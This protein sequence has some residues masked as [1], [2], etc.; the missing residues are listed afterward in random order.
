[1]LDTGYL[2]LVEAERR[3]RFS[4]DIL[5]FARS[6]IQ[7]H[8]DFGELSRVVSSL[9]GRSSEKAQTGINHPGSCNIANGIH[10]NG[11]SP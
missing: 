11:S 5:Q 1:M 9:P 8:P 2:M 3:S 10:R 4:G 6:E 7:K